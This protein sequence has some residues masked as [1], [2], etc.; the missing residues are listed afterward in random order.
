MSS[1]GQAT[2]SLVGEGEQP[3]E[4]RGRIP[5]RSLLAGSLLEPNRRLDS[6]ELA[7]FALEVLGR[8]FPTQSWYV[9][10]RASKLLNCENLGVLTICAREHPYIP[11][12]VA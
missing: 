6:I 2:L 10:S 4:C 7:G 5:N 9:L 8:P 1:P 11:P 12:S 3:V